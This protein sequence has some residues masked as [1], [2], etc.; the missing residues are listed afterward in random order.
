VT[1]PDSFRILATSRKGPAIIRHGERPV[2]G[3][4]F[5]PEVRNEWLIE[6]FLAFCSPETGN[7]H[8]AD[9]GEQAS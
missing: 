7:E 1:L 9:E 8:E 3:V 5:H 4:L 6:R 2:Y